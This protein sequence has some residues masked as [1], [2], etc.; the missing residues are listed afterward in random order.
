MTEASEVILPPVL[1]P[2]VQELTRSGSVVRWSR[3]P[4]HNARSSDFRA[5]Q[6]NL[7]DNGTVA[8]VFHCKGKNG[9]LFNAAA[10]PNVPS[11]DAADIKRW[12]EREQL[13]LANKGQERRNGQ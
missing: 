3:C 4:E 9:H 11:T 2:A 1:P 12:R 10:D 13:R 6:P 7:F 8:W 5:V